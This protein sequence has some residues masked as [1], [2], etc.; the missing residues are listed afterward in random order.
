MS[1]AG[2]KRKRE[3]GDDF[4]EEDGEDEVDGVQKCI[5]IGEGQRIVD[6]QEPFNLRG[7]ARFGVLRRLLGPKAQASRTVR[8]PL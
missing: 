7:L 4:E 3:A 1:R 8:L 2:R 5:N 6:S